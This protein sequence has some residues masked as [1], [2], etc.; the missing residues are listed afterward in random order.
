MALLFLLAKTMLTPSS[1]SPAAVKVDKA[2]KQ[3]LMGPDWT[4]NMEICDAI[5]SDQGFAKNAM[6]ALKKRLQHKNPRVQLLALTLL[7]TMVKNCGDNIH[8]HIAE[9]KILD[10]MIKIVK[11][12]SDMQVRDKVL[13]LLDSWGEAFGGPGGKHSQYYQ[14]CDELR[15]SGVVFPPRSFDSAPISTPPV[16]QPS[17]RHHQASTGMS[18]NSSTKLDKAIASEVEGLSISSMQSMRNVMELLADMLQAVNPEDQMA[19]KDEVIVDLADRCHANQKKLM[20]MLTTTVDEELLA[21][22]LELHDAM[23]SV[24]AKHDA[25]ASG[26]PLITYRT[27]H[28]SQADESPERNLK[29]SE[30]R[31]SSSPPNAEGSPSKAD[32]KMQTIEPSSATPL[33]RNQVD[34]EEE[35]DEFAQL[36]RRHSK[37]HPNM[38]MGAGKDIASSSN[39]SSD[40]IPS[41]ASSDSVPSNASSDSVPSNALVF[42]DIR[43]PVK[44]TKEQD[45]I[46][47]LSIVLS[48]SSTSPLEPQTPE[49]APPK[50]QIPVTVSSQ[51]TWTPQGYN[52]NHVHVP[53][54]SYVVPWAQ[55]QP[56][57]LFQSQPQTQLQTRPQLQAQQ[58]QAQ[59]G[60][61]QY[62]SGFPSPWAATSGYGNYQNSD[63]TGQHSYSTSQSMQGVQSLQQVY[64]FQNP[65]STAQHTLSPSPVTVGSSSTV[66]SQGVQSL[67]HM[68]SFQY[69]RPVNPHIIPTSQPMIPVTTTMQGVKSLQQMNSLPAKGSN[70]LAMNGEIRATV[71]SLSTATRQQP[72]I[73][74]YRLFEDLNVFGNTEAKLRSGPYPSASG[75]LNQSMVGGRR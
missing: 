63:S 71:S 51:D 60:D 15:R 56:Q 17:A 69:Q 72:Y 57:Q 18:I 21:L 50:R 35:D 32:G 41:N 7:E 58:L 74:S 55:Q 25:I 19:V 61:L 54:N 33:G 27:T 73:P 40:S 3:L 65:H 75:N 70:G 12:R 49:T 38:P 66:P 4:M 62:S 30:P 44:T 47:L 48:T 64:S 24:L 52:G 16:A 39:A 6:K 37:P 28:R 53:Y 2:T 36:A 9:K 5:N 20:Q 43:A 45:M 10:E 34:E 26:T 13:V 8:F 59:P 1:L 23:Q 11:K 22:G 31:Y 67:Q 68:V 14:A 42:P 29:P 46:G